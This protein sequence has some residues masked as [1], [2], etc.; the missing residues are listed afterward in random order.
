MP[1][2]VRTGAFL[3]RSLT[4][5]QDLSPVAH[6][7]KNGQNVAPP[8]MIVNGS[9]NGISTLSE[10][11]CPR[12]LYSQAGIMRSAPSKMPMYQSGWEADEMATGVYGPY[13]QIGLIWAN[14]AR[15]AH[16]PKMKKNHAPPLAMKY[17]KNGWPV[18]FCSVFPLAG[19]WVCFWWT[20]MNRCAVIS[21]RIRPGNRNTWVMYILGTIE[22][23]G[24]GPPN[25]KNA[26]YVPTI[27]M[28]CSTPS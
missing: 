20:M 7:S 4:L 25:K 10:S 9:A 6:C 18:T 26:R 16:A 5:C 28:P 8:R 24:N 27:G 11:V 19:I 14:V 3:G 2:P 22:L 12:R 17:G 15:K 1:T 13:S 23:P 21:A